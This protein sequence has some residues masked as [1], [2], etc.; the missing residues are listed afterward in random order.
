MV[1]AL[2]GA[3]GSSMSWHSFSGGQFGRLLKK[4]TQKTSALFDPAILLLGI[5][6]KEII[7]SEHKDDS[8]GA[9]ITE[10]LRPTMQYVST[11]LLTLSALRATDD[12]TD[13]YRQV[14][15]YVWKLRR[16]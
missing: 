2:P 10:G 3:A 16:R 14:C 8:S 5:F 1:R 4:K 11:S 13:T 15:V 7:R 6:P 12:M 9:T